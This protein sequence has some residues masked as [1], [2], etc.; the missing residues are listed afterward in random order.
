MC[1]LLAFKAIMFFSSREE[2]HGA[3]LCA[4]KWDSCVQGVVVKSGC[5]MWQIHQVFET[6]GG[7]SWSAQIQAEHNVALQ[8]KKKKSQ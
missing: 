6:R 3:T 7:Q 2:Q 5:I 4:T 8:I 1:V